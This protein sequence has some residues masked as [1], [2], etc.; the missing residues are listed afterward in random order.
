MIFLTMKYFADGVG[1]R[2]RTRGKINNL[3][4]IHQKSPVSSLLQIMIQAGK[5]Q[6]VPRHGWSLIGCNDVFKDLKVF[7]DHHGHPSVRVCLMMMQVGIPAWDKNS[8]EWR[9]VQKIGI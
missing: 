9:V 3:P 7:E 4:L 1:E 8:V 6:V 5:V 2:G